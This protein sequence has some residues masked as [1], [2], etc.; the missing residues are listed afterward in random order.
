M[1]TVYF[2]GL[3]NKK[4]PRSE[5]SITKV[6][7]FSTERFYLKVAQKDVTPGN[8]T[9]LQPT[10]TNFSNVTGSFVTFRCISGTVA[11]SK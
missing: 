6:I 2:S 10:T 7:L 1:S 11:P 3:S 8:S 5:M 9:V 4:T